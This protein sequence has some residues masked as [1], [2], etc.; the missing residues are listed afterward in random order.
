MKVNPAFYYLTDGYSTQG[1]KLMGRQAAGE[2]FLHG[3]VKHSGADKFHCLTRRKEVFAD[4][5]KRFLNGDSSRAVFHGMSNLSS[6][7]NPGMAFIPS[8]HIGDFSWLRR[9][10]PSSDFS[11]CGITHTT[12]SAAVMQ[13]IGNLVTAPLEEWDAL[14][15]TSN[16]VKKMVSGIL[17][18]WGD[19]LSEKFNAA[20]PVSPVQLP[21][22][23]LGVDTD[24][25]KPSEETT[26]ARAR[27]RKEF[28]ISEND[29]AVLFVGRFSFHAKAHPFPMFAALEKAAQETG[30]RV[31]LLQAGWFPND[32]VRDSFVEGA[33]K[34]APSVTHVMLDGR[35]PEYRKSVWFA[36]DIFT[37]LSDNIQETFGLTPIEA[38]AAGL[39]SVVTDW[40]GYK[41]TVRHEIDG[42][43]VNTYMPEPGSAVDLSYRYEAEIDNYDHYC[44]YT[45]IATAVDVEETAQ[46]YAALIG[47]AGLRKK[48][49]DAARTRASETYDW[50]HIVTSYQDLWADLETRRKRTSRPRIKDHSWINPLRPDPFAAFRHYPSQL[51]TK[52]SEISLE[53]HGNI[54]SYLEYRKTAFFNFGIMAGEESFKVIIAKLLEGPKTILELQSAVPGIAPPI[55]IRSIAWLIKAGLARSR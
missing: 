24:D 26:A 25:F 32:Q 5:S 17:E 10:W 29:I 34:F 27:I 43:R 52:E 33:Q 47:N 14:I 53:P 11:L 9:R 23:P 48:M 51:I 54:D 6:L 41:D 16:A 49:G 42:F 50:K 35:K 46:A 28:S 37:S 31:F 13:D 18:H 20:P 1:S 39:P 45:S 44:A 15:C 4:F 2:G 38:M 12:A 8:P 21:V 30:E 7:S 36:A 22:I 19:Y 3:Y 40:D 55:L